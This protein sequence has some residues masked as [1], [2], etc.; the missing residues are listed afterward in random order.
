MSVLTPPPKKKKKIHPPVRLR[1]QTYESRAELVSPLPTGSAYIIC[2]YRGQ[3]VVKT[4]RFLVP[5]ALCLLA[6]LD[7]KVYTVY[8]RQING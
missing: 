4:M 2:L 7:A 1:T 6:T 8:N 5:V 3:F